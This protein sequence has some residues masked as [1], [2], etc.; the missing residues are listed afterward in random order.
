MIYT[1]I[2]YPDTNDEPCIVVMRKLDDVKIFYGVL[3]GLLIRNFPL[4]SYLII[5]H[6][7]SIY[8]APSPFSQIILFS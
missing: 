8:D 4:L 7:S 2:I 5:S 3:I 1:I 6:P